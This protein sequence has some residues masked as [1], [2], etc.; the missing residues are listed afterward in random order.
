VQDLGQPG[1]VGALQG[2]SIGLTVAS[3]GAVSRPPPLCG[4]ARRATLPP[5]G[6]PGPRGEDAEV[7]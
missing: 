4:L 1:R 7:V 3:R 2:Y 6:G 5:R